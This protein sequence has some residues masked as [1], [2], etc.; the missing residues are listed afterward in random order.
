MGVSPQEDC[1][2]KDV[3]ANSV[4]V[5]R[6]PESHES[7]QMAGSG[8]QRADLLLPAEG[9]HHCCQPPCAALWGDQHALP[10]CNYPRRCAGPS[11]AFS[12]Q[13]S[14]RF[15][16]EEWLFLALRPSPKPSSA[17]LTFQHDSVAFHLSE[18]QQCPLM[19][20]SLLFPVLF[21]INFPFV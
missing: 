13:A 8:L 5:G 3:A 15:C 10:T 9:H 21:W 20:I 11:C 2:Y 17:Q 18:I 7:L 14:P 16:R 19:D 12:V 1:S 4:S 6:A